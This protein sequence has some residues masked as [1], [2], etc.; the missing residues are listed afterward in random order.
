MQ[1][2]LTELSVAR[3]KPPKSGRTEIWD[4]TLPAFGVRVSSRGRSYVVAIRKPGAKHPS[5]L[6][7]GEPGSM[8]LADARAK[9]RTLMADP[10]AL[11]PQEQAPPDT[12]ASVHRRVHR[13]RSEAA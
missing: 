3:I 13:A 11:K 7:V 4:S 2:K 9:A 8:S 6:K 1:K 12:V 5:R 10:D